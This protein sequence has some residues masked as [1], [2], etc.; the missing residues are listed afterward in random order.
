[1]AKIKCRYGT[2]V[3]LLAF[4]CLSATAQPGRIDLPRKSPEILREDFILLKKI[5]EANHPSLYWYT[6]KDSM[7]GY[8]SH[9]IE[10]ITDSLNEIEFKNKVSQVISKIRCG[11][12]TVFFSK[13][14]TK[15]IAKYRYPL[16]PLNL[17][18]WGD[19][20]VV[21]NSLLAGDSIFKRGTIVTGINGRTN[22]ELMDS[23]FQF[24]SSDGYAFNYKY[25]TVSNNFPGWYKTIFGVDSV[26]R[27]S[28]RDS[29]GKEQTAVLK[30]FNP[31]KDSLR[32]DSLPV[33]PARP[34]KRQIK[35]MNLLAK[36]ALSID[37]LQQTAYMRLTTFSGGGLRKF[38][39]RSFR[40]IKENNILHLVIDLRENGGGKVRNSVLL[41]KYLI[42]HP[43][44]IGDTV[45]AISRKLE[46]G[47]YIKPSLPFWFAMNFGAHKSE[48]GKIHFRH[49][50]KTFYEPK[51]KYHY[52]GKLYL[53]QGGLSFSAATMFLATIKGQQNVTI[54]GEESGGGYYGNSAMYLPTITLPNSKLRISLPLYRLVMDPSRPRGTGVMPDLNIPPSSVAIKKGID[55]KMKKIQ[56]L[57]QQ[58]S[59][60]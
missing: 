39:R 42:D 44:K 13:A 34:T 35:Q 16:F 21:L 7:D 54:A 17:K 43:F 37:T 40:K 47:R 30:N 22:R 15:N 53:L 57:I 28:Y 52:A 50:E 6:P 24:I 26:Y 25:Q 33:A 3:F 11:H 2:V 41:T 49:Y 29:I 20:L 19:S 56:E 38:F 9:A 8:F 12:T 46:Y 60:K 51:E 4:S 27:I 32:K 10:S 58:N 5:L 18:A 31:R 45:V 23:F 1:M 48:D 55:L 36:R 14:Y 59:I